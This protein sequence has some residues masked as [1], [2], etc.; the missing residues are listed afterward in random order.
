MKRNATMT[1]VVAAVVLISGCGELE[2]P[3]PGYQINQSGNTVSSGSSASFIN[4]SAIIV[5]SGDTVYGLSVRHNVSMRDIIV[6]N[7]LQAPYH[8]II[9]Q[10]IVLPR[11]KI[12][13]V[14]KN[15]T[16]FGISQ[17]YNV[18][19]YDLARA[20][21]VGSPYIIY[22]G[23]EIRIPGTGTSQSTYT[24]AVTPVK[25]P[26]QSA[27]GPDTAT[28]AATTG[29]TMASAV[30]PAKPVAAIP[31]P[32]VVSGE[33]FIWPVKGKLVSGYGEKAEGLRND[34]INIAAP[35]GSDVRAVENGVVAYAGNELRGFGNLLLIKHANGYVSAY[36]HNS[37]LLV[38]RGDT[39]KKGQ[40]IARVGSTG[41]VVDPQL[42]FELR[43]GKKTLNPVKVL[44]P[45]GV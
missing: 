21:S 11:G 2:W 33:G 6:A 1:G 7:N 4:A 14:R 39:V 16:L 40:A 31:K 10:R 44:P 41:N 42:H 15:E 19:A 30:P 34:G 9:G 45:Q 12:H 27:T 8:L 25:P 13:V 24:P 20:N 5:G 36:A 22:V 23:Q 32:P 43:K 38:N 28:T 29:S 35:E 18:N 26:A 3:P 17:I 37:N